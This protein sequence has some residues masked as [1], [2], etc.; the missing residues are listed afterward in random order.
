M[1]FSRFPLFLAK[2]GSDLQSIEDFFIR[3]APIQ[4]YKDLANILSPY[5]VSDGQRIEDVAFD[6]YGDQNL[7]WVILLCNGITNPY[8]DWPVD[9][10]VL[11][12]QIY[13]NYNFILGVPAGHGLVVGDVVGSSNGYTFSVELTNTESLVLKSLE[14][15]AY[16][17]KEDFIYNEKASPRIPISITSVEDPM[18]TIH[19]YEDIETGYWVDFDANKLGLG[20]IRAISNLQYEESVNEKKRAIRILDKKYLSDFVQNFERELQK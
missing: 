7:H 4:Q 11:Y 5:F 2:I 10:N 17:S 19:H 3:I 15:V 1:F 20:E 18:N 14:G 13:Q 9:M 8:K 16:L 12:K 6:V